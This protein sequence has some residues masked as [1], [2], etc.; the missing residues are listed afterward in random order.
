MTD[1]QE[2]HKGANAAE[3]R[4]LRNKRYYENKK[5]SKAYNPEKMFSLVRSRCDKL[6]P[7]YAWDDSPGVYD[8][9]AGFSED[10]LLTLVREELK[11]DITRAELK[12]FCKEYQIG[13]TTPEAKRLLQRAIDEFYAKRRDRKIRPHTPWKRTAQAVPA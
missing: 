12:S 4:K 8:L 11:P 1:K 6:W 5:Q 13:L 10:D 3:L 9:K 2:S 7:V